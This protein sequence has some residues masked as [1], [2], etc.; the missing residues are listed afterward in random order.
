MA[1]GTPIRGET[2]RRIACEAGIIPIVLGGPSEI[3][4]LGRK[5]RLASAAQH[6]ALLVRAHACEF[7]GCDIP[8]QWTKAH[9][10]NPWKPRN[11]A[12]TR[13]SGGGDEGDRGGAGNSGDEGD[14]G[15]E[16]NLDELV[17]VCER[18]HHLLHEGGWNIHRTGG[19][20][21]TRKPDGT[22]HGP[23]PPARTAA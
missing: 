10:V 4:D 14:Q 18:H 23:A 11:R 12:A 6:R 1:D 19:V 13:A 3:L 21:Y 5:R 22:W 20:T 7:W 16:T 15:G 2:A 8:A 17:L 9:H